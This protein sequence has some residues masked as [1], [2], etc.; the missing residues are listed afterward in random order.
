M[1]NVLRILLIGP[2]NVGKSTIPNCLINNNVLIDKL[3]TPAQTGMSTLGTTD[4]FVT[5]YTDKFVLTDSIGLDDPKFDIDDVFAKFRQ[6]VRSAILGFNV[7][8]F[9]L[10][11]GVV[12]DIHRGFLNTIIKMFGLGVYK[13]L[14]LAI[15]HSDDVKNDK[16]DYLNKVRSNDIKYYNIIEDIQHILKI[17]FQSSVNE[18]K[19]KIFYEDRLKSLSMI[20]ECIN[21]YQ[22]TKFI[23]IESQNLNEVFED[24]YRYFFDPYLKLKK[25]N[26]DFLAKD[27][28][29]QYDKLFSANYGDCVIC[30]EFLIKHENNLVLLECNHIFHK[31]C[32]ESCLKISNFCPMCKN[33]MEIVKK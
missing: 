24:F 32:F 25:I 11:D 29:Q 13:K 16:M 19:D 22:N 26:C 20:K 33:K 15:T 3:I 2:S 12:T 17:N 7:I 23:K 10:K 4:R 9:V 27:L 30:Y 8:V 28:R 21:L 18:N 6:L 1:E 31:Q 5:Y 14:I